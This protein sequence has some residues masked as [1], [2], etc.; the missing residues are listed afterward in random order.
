MMPNL[1]EI[2]T[3]ITVAHRPPLIDWLRGL[4]PQAG[5]GGVPAARHGDVFGLER[6][7][8]LKDCVLI[9]GDAS[10]R[11]YYRVTYSSAK[12]DRN[13]TMIGVD[14]P[15]SENNDAFLAIR[16]LFESAGIRVPS[17]IAAELPWGYWLLEDLGDDTLLPLLSDHSVSVW[18]PKALN[19]LAAIA[20]VDTTRAE[21]PPYDANRLTSELALF[22][23]WFVP[24]LLDLDLSDQLGPV[25]EALTALLVDNALS[26][27]QVLVHRDYHSRNLMVLNN[28][29]L[30]V[31]DFQDAVI[32]PLTYDPVSLLKDCY[33]RWSRERQLAWL[34]DY[35]R[36]LESAGRLPSL[37]EATLIRW[38]DLMGLQRHLKVLGIFA[39]L[40]LRDGKQAYLSDLPRVLAYVIE[41]LDLYADSDAP[42]G[43]FRAV[44]S[45]R[46]LPECHKATWFA[47]EPA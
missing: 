27:P 10:P 9:A 42:I 39:R 32:G 28:H 25:Y 45:A 19:T 22:S 12:A 26:Q 44:F 5:R 40:A 11:K 38:F 30:A 23:D 31:I 36:Q 18:Y 41:V 46:I 43:D 34:R 16:A 47:L 8:E 17:L 15:A 7:D 29:D 14:S 6:V 35:Q 24:Q 4:L 3:S 37:P 13:V 33:L 21:L 20:A 1:G 2:L